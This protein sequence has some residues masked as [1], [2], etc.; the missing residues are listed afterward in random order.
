MSLG[1]GNLDGG[2]TVYYS[3]MTVQKK[4]EKLMTI[5]FQHGRVQIGYFDEVVHGAEK[6]NNGN[7][8]VINFCMKKKLVNFL[9][10]LEKNIIHNLLLPGIP[11]ACT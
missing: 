11:E 4:G 3:G 6:W 2:S 10:S 5:P 9:F 7:R 8:G 1:D